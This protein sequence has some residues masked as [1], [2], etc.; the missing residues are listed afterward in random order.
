MQQPDSNHE[1]I[2]EGIRAALREVKTRDGSG[3]SASIKEIIKIPSDKLPIEPKQLLLFLEKYG[4]LIIDRAHGTLQA[5]SE[6]ERIA[7]GEGISKIKEY[8][9]DQFP[10]RLKGISSQSSHQYEVVDDRFLKYG[11]IGSGSVAVVYRGEQVSTQ[12]E[13]AIKEFREIF[14]YF[15]V[16]QR[17]EILRRLERAV[18]EHA[19]VI[20]PNILQI[21][22]GNAHREVPYF[23]SELAPGGNLRRLIGQSEPISANSICTFFV[24]ICHGLKCAHSL[25]LVHRGIKPENVLFDVHGNVKLSDFGISRVVERGPGKMGQIFISMGSV[26]YMAPEQFQDP[27]FADIRTDIYA[28]G[29]LFYEMCTGRLPG[30]RSPMPSELRK[31]LPKGLDDIFDRMTQDDPDE[32]YPLVEA[33]LDDLYKVKEIW[34]LLDRRGA[35]LM[36][37]GPFSEIDLPPLEARP[38]TPWAASASGAPASVGSPGVSEV[39]LPTGPGAKAPPVVREVRPPAAASPAT[40]PPAGGP[41]RTQSSSPRH[42]LDLTDVPDSDDDDDDEGGGQTTV[43]PMDESDNGPI[44]NGP[45]TVTSSAVDGVEVGS[46]STLGPDIF[47]GLDSDARPPGPSEAGKPDFDI[48]GDLVLDPPPGGDRSPSD[49]GGK[50]GG[51]GQRSSSASP[52]STKEPLTPKRR[53]GVPPR[54]K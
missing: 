2:I 16:D 35:V 44:S 9:L 50:A 19:R 6:G 22:E 27:R 53:F 18:A 46:D 4:Y 52:R 39:A 17:S 13:V 48:D 12:R 31:D 23:V 32:R 15:N 43:G 51:L 33:I 25:D 7:K 30:R 21:I 10:G 24:Q 26:G 40:S 36:H 11:A 1:K 38:S 14:S 41:P 54:R 45:P 42:L 28:L 8:L 37:R 3:A 34:D 5:T 49:D 20:H 47:E 29:I